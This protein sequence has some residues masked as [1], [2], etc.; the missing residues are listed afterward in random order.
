LFISRA[1][2]QVTSSRVRLTG[3]SL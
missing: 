3:Y 1:K 2:K